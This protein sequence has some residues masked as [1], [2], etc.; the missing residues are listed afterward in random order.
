M[1][2]P[3]T[4]ELL[5]KI[6]QIAEPYGMELLPEIHESYSEKIYEKIAEQGYVTY[7]FFL[8]GLIIDALESGNG[9]HLAGWAQELMI[10]IS[11]P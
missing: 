3:D 11:E 4:W 9:E 10:K 5:D 6:K 8:P 1:N 7:D 2:Q